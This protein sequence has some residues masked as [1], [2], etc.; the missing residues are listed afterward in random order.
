[1]RA[2]ALIAWWYGAG[3][4]NEYRLQLQ[5]LSR[6]ENYFAFGSLLRTFFQPFRQIDAGSRR[7][8]LSVQL[9]GWL[10]RAISRFIG[11]SA[12]LVLLVVGVGWWVVSALA[13]VCWLLVW[14]ILPVA[15]VFG[16][17]AAATGVG[18]L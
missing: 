18:M 13:S 14:P 15:P 4:A 10:D 16:I 2:W 7:G 6:V 12:R 11:A 1:M 3:W 5:R 9:H 8:S 17:V